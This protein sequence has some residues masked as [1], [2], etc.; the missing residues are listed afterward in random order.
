M[1][2]YP[3]AKPL[4]FTL[5]AE[6]AHNFSLSVTDQAFRVGLLPAIIGK[7]PRLPTEFCGLHLPNNEK[8]VVSAFISTFFKMCRR[9]YHN[10][11][12]R[13]KDLTR[14]T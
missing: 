7:V 11:C 14:K 8:I 4:L 1:N 3:L 6:P 10:K 12:L 2:L 5:D 9:V 13:A